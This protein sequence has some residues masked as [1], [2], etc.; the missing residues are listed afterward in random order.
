[1]LRKNQTKLT[2]VLLGTLSVGL[3]FYGVRFAM[4]LP[5]RLMNDMLCGN[6]IKQ[7]IPSPDGALKAVIFQRDCGAATGFSTQISLLPVNAAL[8][9]DGGNVFVENKGDAV[10]VQWRDN[11]HL[12]I[13]HAPTDFISERRFSVA[14]GFLQHRAVT[15]SYAP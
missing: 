5:G 6:E 9:D 7:Q 14:V 8:P 4:A 10:S 1:M 13:R 11:G 15:I 2:L 3:L 12:Q